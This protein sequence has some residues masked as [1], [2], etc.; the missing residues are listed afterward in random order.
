MHTE[1]NCEVSARPKIDQTCVRVLCRVHGWC[2]S[3]LR[4]SGCSIVQ[5]NG[6]DLWRSVPGCEEEGIAN[7]LHAD[8]VQHADFRLFWQRLVCPDMRDV[9]A[10][11]PRLGSVFRIPAVTLLAP[12]AGI[13]G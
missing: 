13:A 12:V 7:D 5:F 1:P 4:L 11:L 2:F 3:R 8:P 9:H 10:L 6:C